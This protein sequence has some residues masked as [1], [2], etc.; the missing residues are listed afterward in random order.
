[1]ILSPFWWGIV[2]TLDI[3]RNAMQ[4][5]I[6]KTALTFFN[7]VII[8]QAITRKLS[9]IDL[10]QICDAPEDYVQS[11][12]PSEKG[13]EKIAAAIAEL[14]AGRLSGQQG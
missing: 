3:F 8:R 1:M 12:E 7:D 6:A 13:G 5:E 10:R 14:L 9:F 11:I 2:V 4:Y